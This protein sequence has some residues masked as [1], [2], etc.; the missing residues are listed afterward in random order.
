MALRRARPHSASRKIEHSSMPWS[1]PCETALSDSEL[2]RRGYALT[3]RRIDGA[4]Q[5]CAAQ[6]RLAGMRRVLL[7]RLVRSR[8]A[9]SVLARTHSRARATATSRARTRCAPPARAWSSAAPMTTFGACLVFPVL[10]PPGVEPSRARAPLSIGVSAAAARTTPSLGR[11][12][13][14]GCRST[15][16]WAAA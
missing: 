2:A 13:F 1:R 3:A 5:V 16:S 4:G 15:P 7:Q 14:T 10:C 6:G 8:Y 12:R 11:A 9:W